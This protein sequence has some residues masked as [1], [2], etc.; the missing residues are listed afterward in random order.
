[1]WDRCDR[2]ET[3]LAG[4]TQNLINIWIH[5]P[6]SLKISHLSIIVSASMFQLRERTCATRLWMRMNI[7][8]GGA[9]KVG[10]IFQRQVQGADNVSI[11]NVDTK[12]HCI[13]H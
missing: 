8:H 5:F 3:D 11:E 6:I 12:H 2:L 4:L 9:M 13:T 10:L 1:M 7:I